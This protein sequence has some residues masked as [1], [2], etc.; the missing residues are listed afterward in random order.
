MSFNLCYPNKVREK[1]LCYSIN[2]MKKKNI[3]DILHIRML[4]IR[5]GVV[6]NT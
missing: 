3:F 6:H 1:N 2:I 4:K 5:T